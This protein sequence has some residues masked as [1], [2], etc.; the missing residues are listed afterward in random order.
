M[1]CINSKDMQYCCS[2]LEE[3]V[4]FP[5][6]PDMRIFNCSTG[7]FA[8]MNDISDNHIKKLSSAKM[9]SVFLQ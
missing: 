5:V 2:P 7:N 4:Q 1:L 8:N 6:S 9:N 3:R